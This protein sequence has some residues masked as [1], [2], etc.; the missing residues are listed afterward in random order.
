MASFF[1]YIFQELAGLLLG[2]IFCKMAFIHEKNEKACS[3]TDTSF[4]HALH[5]LRTEFE[6]PPPINRLGR[7]LQT[8]NSRLG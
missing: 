6:G 8:T 3:L 2:A 5:I 4:L 1:S 7:G